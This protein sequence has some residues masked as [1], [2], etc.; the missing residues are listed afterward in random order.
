[1]LDVDGI[2]YPNVEA[3]IAELPDAFHKVSYVAQHSPSS[4]IATGLRQHLFFLL[5]KAESMIV[6]SDTIRHLNFVTKSLRDRVKLTTSNKI[7]S[8]PLD[9][10]A[11]KNGRVVYITAPE[12]V[13]F[14]DPLKDRIEVVSKDY[15]ELRFNFYAV[16]PDEMKMQNRALIDELRATAGLPKIRGEMYTMTKSGEVLRK[17]HT[18]RGR[19]H[20]CSLD[21][22]TIMRCNIDG[23]DSDAY[24]Y[25][26]KAP[27]LIRNHKGEPAIF[28]EAFDPTYYVDV[29]LPAARILWEKE[30]Q[31][32][33]FRNLYDDKYYVGLRI[34]DDVTQQPTF[35]GSEAKIEDYFAQHGGHGVPDPIDT[36]RMEFNPTLDGQWNPSEKIFN[37]W[38]KTDLQESAMFRS[39]PPNVITKIISHAVGSDAEAYSQFINWLAYIYQK[40]TKTGTA[41][42]FHGVQGTGKGLLIDH[43]LTPIFGHDY[44]AKQQ[45]RNLRAEFNGWMEHAIFV[46]LDEFDIQDAGGEATSVMQA[47]KMWITDLRLPIRAMHKESRQTNNYSNFILTT[48]AKGA[49]PVDSGDRRISFGVRQENRLEI[50]PE[51]VEAIP[52]ELEQFAGYLLGYNVDKRLAHTCLEN[53]TKEQAKRL[54][55]TSIEE[56]V[57]AVREGDL[58]FFLDAT[59]ERSSD[60]GLDGAYRKLVDTFID[61]TKRNGESIITVYDLLTAFKVICKEDRNMKGNKFAK[62]MEHKNFPA[63]KL[64]M[65]NGSRPRGWRIEWQTEQETLVNIGGHIKA[66]KTQEELEKSLR[67]EVLAS[68]RASQ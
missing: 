21:S 59:H 53:A 2:D 63:K 5:D 1:M 22:D 54:S 17:R 45:S 6:A 14:E 35:I 9:W 23:G 58:Q 36:W 7:L 27:A 46:N 62:I 49:M 66:A 48:N 44:V 28:M 38:R 64:K 43:I 56:F 11:N 16:T 31:P 8:L 61:D 51:E 25:Y 60:M 18:D 55:L 24:F 4:G 50:S 67:A 42:I 20:D 41:W 32:F 3:F 19:I 10:I 40:R 30:T 15:D 37:T 52:N 34:G 68:P 29:A 13:G 47:L 26:V 65:P 33:V 39:L 12:C 57:E